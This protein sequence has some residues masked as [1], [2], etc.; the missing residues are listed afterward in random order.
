MTDAGDELV[1][2]ASYASRVEADLAASR[3]RA[4]GIDSLVSGPDA[5]GTLQA[6][7]GG[8]RLLVHADRAAEAADVLRDD[9]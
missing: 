9:A 4:A 2:V 1:A 8:I 6:I 7:P 3:L 5:G